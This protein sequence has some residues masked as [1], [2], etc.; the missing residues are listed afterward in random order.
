[1]NWRDFQS[2]QKAIEIGDRFVSYVDEGAGEP[3]V[4]I[5]GIPTRGY[6]WHKLIPVL[7]KQNRVLTPDLIGFGYSDK[8]D[9]F[10]R[11]IDKQ[12]ELIDAWMNEIGIE[13]AHIVAHDIG[14][15]VALT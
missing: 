13:A 5:H 2:K 14:G 11:A 8:G 6:L 1:M 9:N 12:A 10:D 15:G 3:I 4:L 7:F